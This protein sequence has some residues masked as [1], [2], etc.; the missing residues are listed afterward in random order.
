MTGKKD[1]LVIIPAY[2]E[3]KN[4]QTVLKGLRAPEI[5]QVADVLFVNDFSSDHTADLA[6]E[7]G[8]G[9]IS[10]PYNMGYGNS[11]QLGYKY[12]AK[13]GYRFVI[14]MDAD[15]QHDC[16]NILPIYHELQRE[17]EGRLPDI[18]IGS[19]FLASKESG[20]DMVVS[21][22]KKAAIN[23]FRKFIVLLT[24][25]L[26]LD[27]TS[28]LQGLS[29]EAFTRYSQYGNFDDKFPDSNMILQMLL[30]GYEIREVPA[31]MHNRTAGV[32]MHS[33][34]KP[35][36]YM[37]RMT[38]SIIAVWLHIRLFGT[39]KIKPRDLSVKKNETTSI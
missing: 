39:Q 19:R 5:Q 26:V 13:H 34:L 27:P 4:I 6:R 18:V 12:A 16:C 33:G 3:E 15:G 31:V 24:G 30:Y 2:N 35:L 20:N 14:Q 36:I 7:A 11:I 25:K 1:V 37:L 21:K 17:N 8:Y 29:K 10:N 22:S 23:M 32:S 28:G 9:L 38:L